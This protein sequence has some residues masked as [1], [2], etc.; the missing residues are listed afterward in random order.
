MADKVEDPPAKDELIEDPLADPP[1]EDPPA[2]DP[3][4]EDPPAEDPPKAKKTIDERLDEL[5]TT[6]WEMREAERNA[7]AATERA[8]AATEKLEAA[9]AKVGDPKPEEDNFDSNAEWVEALTDWKVKQAGL[10]A[11]AKPSGDD[12]PAATPQQESVLRDWDLRRGKAAGKYKG[13][14]ENE[15]MTTRVL[16]HYNNVDL[17]NLLMESEVGPEIVN[18]LGKNPDKLERIAKLSSLSAAKEIGRLEDQ[19]S[20]TVKKRTNSPAPI[21]PGGGGGGTGTKDYA[22]MSDEQFQKERNEAGY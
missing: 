8:N 15:A 1:A 20:K 14:A 13:Y 6:T 9:A 5:N 21:S 17:T 7:N 4:A 3:P 19:L 11:P 22:Q 10:G 18:H 2:A 12:P 16:K